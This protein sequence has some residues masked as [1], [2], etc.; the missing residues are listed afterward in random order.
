MNPL[1]IILFTIATRYTDS[2]KNN[3]TTVEFTTGE[4]PSAD[5]QVQNAAS[6]AITMTSLTL[7]WDL[8]NDTDGYEGV[9]ISVQF[10]AD[11]TVTPV[12]LDENATTHEFTGLGSA[13][14][15]IFTIAT[16]YSDVGKNN[17]ITVAVT[18]VGTPT[19]AT[20]VQNIT[21]AA[22][23]ATTITLRWTLPTDRRGYEGVNIIAVL[24]L[25][26]AV[27]RTLP[28]RSG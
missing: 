21:R 13:V 5:T 10:P 28:G 26:L 12:E 23:S 18:T 2:G 17:T 14:D 8:P 25:R 7:N 4:P 16:R 19:E 24:T 22:F 11:S 6:D 27:A 9:T 1:L 20:R 15:Y 3:T